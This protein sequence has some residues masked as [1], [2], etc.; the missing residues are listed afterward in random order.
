[1]TKEEYKKINLEKFEKEFKGYVF[2]NYSKM[3][4]KAFLSQTIDELYELPEKEESSCPCVSEE[5]VTEWEKGWNACIDRITERT[6]DLKIKK[7][8]E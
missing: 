5:G 8:Y 7:S 6:R 3:E 1:M 2:G 4:I